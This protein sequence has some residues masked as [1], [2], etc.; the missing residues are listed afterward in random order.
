MFNQIK[1]PH[2]IAT[3]SCMDGPAADMYKIMTIKERSKRYREKWKSFGSLS[4]CGAG[5]KRFFP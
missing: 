3:S 5:Q 4:F 1:N 2:I